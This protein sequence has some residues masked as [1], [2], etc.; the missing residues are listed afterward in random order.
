MDYPVAVLDRAPRAA[1]GPPPVGVFIAV[2]AHLAVY[3]LPV[4]LLWKGFGLL[5]LYRPGYGVGL[6]GARLEAASLALMALAIAGLALAAGRAASAGCA[7]SLGGYASMLVFA[8]MALA[9][10]GIVAGFVGTML[11]AVGLWRL[12]SEPCGRMVRAG[13]A[14]QLAGL[15]LGFLPW[16]G[17]PG[18]AVWL[19][20][21]VLAVLGARRIRGRVQRGRAS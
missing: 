17:L 16:G 5:R 13:V 1:E 19:V 2:F 6:T 7:S 10:A 11:V 14:L 18:E 9:F 15:P 3:S 21:T 12:G 4:Y 20:G 8:A